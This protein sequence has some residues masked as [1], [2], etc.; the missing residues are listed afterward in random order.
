MA[1]HAAYMRE[2]LDLARRGTG[3]VSPNPR[4][5]ALLVR[6]GKVVARGYHRR[7]GGPHAEVECLRRYRGPMGGTTL[8]VNLEPCAHAGK[9]PPCTDL[10]VRRGIRAVVVGMPDP[11]PLVGGRGIRA[12][13]GAGLRVTVGVLRD[14]CA[15]LN[16]DFIT[17]VTRRR[18]YVHVKVAQ[19][20]DGRIGRQDAGFRWI[21]SPPSRALVHRW[22]AQYD[23]VLVGARTIRED[24]PRLSVRYARGRDPHAVVL[25][26]ALSINPRARVFRSGK[27]RIV[28]VCTT[29]AA[30]RRSEARVRR[31]VKA[32][33]TL[34]V[35]PGKK[36]R[37][38][39]PE[40]L[41]A[42][43]DQGVG[44]LF[45]E[46]GAEVF[47]Q[48]LAEGLVDE[49]SVFVAPAFAGSGVPAL[50]SSAGPFRVTHLR[51]EMP[52]RIGDDLLIRALRPVHA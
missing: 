52:E 8:Y 48:F 5:G 33:A 31:L 11:N 19:T 42:L 46:G 30:V 51:L 12:L 16:R 36:G 44:S 15:A 40:L 10:I 20:I 35:L 28:L 41:R 9:T 2:C 1:D 50:G 4:V 21:T 18:P 27:D 23:A 49:L 24:D 37:I 38:A 17:H 39:L 25:D 26:G 29:P 47:A 3:R 6:N 43:Y 14:E 45:V 34:L 22:R 13:R 7:F 32:G